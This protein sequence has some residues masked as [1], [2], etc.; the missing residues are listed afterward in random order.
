MKKLGI[1][2]ALMILISG[3]SSCIE[4]EIQNRSA[5]DNLKMTSYFDT[6]VF[7]ESD[8]TIYGKWKLY[9]ISGGFAGIWDEVEDND[10]LVI[11]K[12]GIY[13]Y[14]HNNQ[15]VEYGKVSPVA[16]NENEPGLR[17]IFEKDENSGSYLNERDVTA[18]FSDDNTLNLF[19]PCCD[20]FNTHYH[21]KN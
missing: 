8:L 19:A 4:D 14:F 15:L 2:L 1:L 20:R 10:Y 13:G 17:I 12:Y 6:E 5:L 7:A 3:L 18:E 21:R 11:K 9:A 16:P